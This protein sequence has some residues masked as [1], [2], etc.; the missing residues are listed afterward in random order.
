MNNPFQIQ[1]VGSFKI[2][3]LY[4]DSSVYLYPYG[5]YAFLEAL[6]VLEIKSIY[7][8][9]FICRDMLSPINSLNIKYFF[10]EVDEKLEPILDDIKCDSILFVNYF[11]FSQ[12]I[13]PFKEYKNKFGAILIEDNAH[14]FL[15]RDE[16]NTLL[17]T[18]GDI[19]LLS[20]RKTVFLPNGAALLIN[21]EILKSNKFNPSKIDLSDEDIKYD[22]KLKLK[23]K[24]F[25]K[26]IGISILLLRRFIRYMKT[27]TILP[28][29]DKESES[30]LPKNSYLTPLLKDGEVNIDLD[31]EISN[32]I[33]MYKQVEQWA[34]K[35]GIAPIFQLKDFTVP[36]EFMFI[37]NGNYKEFENFLLKK[38]FFILPWPDLADEVTDKCPLFYKNIKVVPFLW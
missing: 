11:G 34:K 17:G 12:N 1:N 15:S 18:R 6:K 4:N 16:N 14:G 13:K 35:F 10:Y 3:E 7:I 22:K 29:P 32:R 33:Q 21:N 31:L 20:I 36:Y 19:G 26:Y 23:N 30:I 5:R 24:I 38:G 2:K 37:D 27:G 28:L 25:H 9:S 8:P